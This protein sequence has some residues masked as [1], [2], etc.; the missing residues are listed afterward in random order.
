MHT[1]FSYTLARPLSQLQL[2]EST[3]SAAAYSDTR[4][5]MPPEGQKLG[6]NKAESG[7]EA[8]IPHTILAR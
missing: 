6:I 5:L 1:L 4:N 8:R 2:S 3:G 7:S